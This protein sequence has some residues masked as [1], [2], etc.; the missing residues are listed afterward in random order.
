MCIRLNNTIFWDNC[1]NIMQKI[2]NGLQCFFFVKH[3]V[4]LA[5][6]SNYYFWRHGTEEVEHFAFHFM[7][8]SHK[9]LQVFVFMFNLTELY[10]IIHD[11]NWV[12]K[13]ITWI[14]KNYII[15]RGKEVCRI[16]SDTSVPE[17]N[18]ESILDI[19]CASLTGNSIEL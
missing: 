1:N 15:I 8:F 2:E 14:L 4:W 18:L 16:W 5:I 9:K 17:C 6:S 3:A 11:V 10:N 19:L 12:R 13:F 7:C